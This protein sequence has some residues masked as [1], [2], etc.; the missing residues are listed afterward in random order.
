MIASAGAR[1]HHV[2]EEKISREEASR[3]SQL[4]LAAGE[5][6]SEAL[7]AEEELY[8]PLASH[9]LLV[10]FKDCDYG[11]Q[12]GQTFLIVA[13][14]FNKQYV[15]RFHASDSLYIFSPRSKIRRFVLFLITHQY[16]ELLILLTILTNCVFLAMSNPPEVAEF[17]FA[18]IYTAEMF[19]K[20][21]GR[22]FALHKYAY[23]RN[24]WNWLDFLVVI[25]GY[26]TMLPGVENLSGIR[27]FRVLRALRTISAVKG[28]KAMVNTLLKSIR[29]LSDVL[30]LTTFFLCVFALIGLQLFVGIMQW[31]CVRTPPDGWPQ[32]NTLFDS[33]IKNDSNHYVFPGDGFAVLCG[34]SSNAN[35]CPAN[36]TCMPNTGP[37]P[38]SRYISYDNFGWALLTSLQLVTMDY[39][40]SIYNSVI[41]TKGP[42]Y[43]FYFFF[44]IFL[45]PFYLINL[46]LAV[47]SLSYEQ[48][49]AALQDEV[50]RAQAFAKVKRTGSTYSFDGKM[51]PEPLYEED[52]KKIAE[53][54]AY[55][56]A[57]AEESEHPIEPEEPTEVAVDVPT[58]PSF[59]R[60]TQTSVAGLVN[61]SAFETLITLCIL[62]NTLAMALEHFRMDKTFAK[63]LEY[64]NLVFTV[65]FIM[66]MVLKLI[67]FGPKEYCKNKWNLFDGAIVILSVLDMALT[68]SNT[69]DGAGLSVL[70]TFRLLRVL[71]LAQSWKTMGDLLNTIGSSVGA[72]GNI[73]VILAII[74]Y[75]FAVV[76]MQIFKE[77]YSI[78]SKFKNNEIPR[79]NFSDFGHSF[80]VI[81]R[82]LCGKWIEPLWWTMRATNPAAIFFILPAFIIGN[83]VILNLFLALLLNSF[84][85][86]GDDEAEDEEAK[87]K[88]EEEKKKKKKRKKKRLDIKR[89]L[90]KNK[91]NVSGSRSKVGPDDDGEGE[92]LD[93]HSRTFSPVDD[94][95]MKEPSLNLSNNL[96]NGDQENGLEMRLVHRV[97]NGQTQQENGFNYNFDETPGKPIGRNTKMSSPPFENRLSL[98]TAIDLDQ[99][100][101]RIRDLADANKRVPCVDRVKSDDR[102]VASDNNFS[103]GDLVANGSAPVVINGNS[104]MSAGSSHKDISLCDDE[105]RIPP[106]SPGH[107]SK[108][109]TIVTVESGDTSATATGVRPCCPA[110]CY[111]ESN[112]CDNYKESCIRRTWHAARFY[113]CGFVEHKYFEWFILAM[114]VISSLTL[115][116]ED[117]NLDKKPVMKN[118]LNV[119]NFIFAVTFTV[120]MLLKIFGM[121]FVGYFTNLWN[122]LDFFI[123]AISLAS[124]TGNKDLQ[125]FRS[126]R[127]LRPL[128]AISR[129]EGMKIVVN[130]LVHAVPAIV[131]VMLV[132]LIFW[133]IFSIVGY[134]LFNGKFYRCVNNETLEKYH[135]TVVKN[136]SMCLKS[137]GMRWMNAKINFDSSLDGFLALFQVATL[138][139]VFEVMDDSVD[140]V[141][142]DQ[143]PEK[144]HSFYSYFYYVIFIIMGSFFIL[145]L[146]IGVIIDNFNRLKQQ[147]EDTGALGMFLTP[148]QRSWVNTIKKTYY[149]KPRRQFK[150]PQNKFRAWLFDLILQKK[151]EVFIMSIILTN[152]VTMMMEHNNQSESFT[153]ALKYLNY[154]FTGIFIIEAVIRLI[155]LR[156]DYFKLGWNVFDFTIVVF[157]IVGIIVEDVLQKD[158]IFSPGLLRV[159]RVFRLGRL[160]RFFEG[161]KGVRRLL[162]TLVKSLPGLVNIA[163]L[164]FLIIFIYAII[165]MSSFGYVK[166]TNGITDVVNFETFGNSMLLL[167]RVGTAAGWNTILDPLM[168]T[169]PDC[170]EKPAGGVPSDC[171]NRILAVIF[172]VTYI[173]IIFLIMINMYIAVI[174]E[175]FNEAQSQ[176]EIGVSDDDLETFIQVW[177]EFDPNASH[178]IALHQL[179]DFLDA[180]EPPLQI[181][182]PNRH[183]FGTLHVPIKAGFRIYCLDL[184]QALVRRA[185]GGLEGHE[186]EDLKMLVDRLEENFQHMR[187]KEDTISSL[188][189]HHSVEISAA[190]R[191]QKAIRL[192]LLRKRLRDCTRSRLRTYQPLKSEKEKGN[193]WNEKQIEDNTHG[194][195]GIE[196]VV[197][198][199]WYQ[200]TKRYEDQRA[201]ATLNEVDE[202]P[203]VETST[204]ENAANGNSETL[205]LTEP[206]KPKYANTLSVDC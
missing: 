132:C 115:A 98:T 193:G 8:T 4:L 130:S 61:S 46:V 25:L 195:Q 146:F 24:A 192:F 66:E 199:L 128:R 191:I 5:G 114:I 51:E 78:K 95:V 112:Y 206:N 143:Q 190:L 33:Y 41:A 77:A 52:A 106:S 2:R 49:T 20:I 11:L 164:L 60:K 189:E 79:W 179:S 183:L 148:G 64:C 80:M 100:A 105:S 172:F 45:G 141:G 153:N 68:Y 126:L 57:R 35:P 123:V 72:V 147:Y 194:H 6:D 163:M 92:D 166:K 13:K 91:N 201:E 27:T 124:I 89:L 162:F 56:A 81:F 48:E 168:V 10:P 67:A 47:V 63:V 187:K 71:K 58:N 202:N 87:K 140:G 59:W 174:L 144:E 137:L 74:V 36:Y 32:D 75:M 23:L 149:R 127:A 175:N 138:E 90:G 7:P 93:A 181:P 65:V 3:R 178:F 18:A 53:R 142:P 102:L 82:I 186:E 135:H 54:E 154:I 110:F 40:E 42:W 55:M 31:K 111:C 196:S 136:K 131:N 88:K 86:G 205:T 129:F 69:I 152:M 104:R 108:R 83:F 99:A 117:I 22:G 97:P 119:M 96:K 145:N 151:F 21:I 107:E 167:F 9:Y 29:M 203:D 177:E 170:T 156:F 155:A 184:M 204:D 150:R 176:E 122:C 62:F 121:G 103:N 171:G 188:A 198:M 39:W 113:V 12:D 165:G 134:Q 44:V 76:G 109:D 159:V 185:I 161:A 38:I 200:Q 43:I 85:G 139:G 50:L 133:L 118:V 16:F 101:L 34:N 180:L 94:N 17:V 70:R 116:F 160:L 1:A 125:S 37:N 28:L 157:S 26:I 173:L 30:I 158:M 19:L 14:K 182:K 169:P 15:Y 120:E 197:A 73:T 84:S